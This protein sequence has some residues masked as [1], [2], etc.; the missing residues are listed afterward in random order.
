MGKNLTKVSVLMSTYNSELNVAKSIESILEQT[1][2]NIEFLIIDD[3]S[4]DNTFKILQEYSK[5]HENIQVFKNEINIGL[6]KSLNFLISKSSGDYIARQ[7]DDDASYPNRIKTQVDLLQNSKI[8]FCTTRALTKPKKR[9]IPGIS[10]YFPTKLLLKYKNPFI[11][12]SLM[13][14]KEILISVGGYDEDFYYSQDLKLII[15]LIQNGNKYKIIN[16]L[17]YVLNTQN[18]ISEKK[19]NEQQYYA[20]CA[21]K[22]IKPKLVI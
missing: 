17:L 4:T 1:Y 21:R 10:Y 16:K 7:D 15:D 3:C 5:N 20:D 13:C 9:K 11:H 12:G 22:G 2:K 19:F 18:N 6:T 8:D 14:K